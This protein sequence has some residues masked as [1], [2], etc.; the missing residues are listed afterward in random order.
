MKEI[1]IL[2]SS[3]TVYQVQVSNHLDD[4]KQSTAS[5]RCS[6]LDFQQRGTLLDSRF[7]CKHIFF[8]LYKV[9]KFDQS[10]DSKD[11]PISQIELGFDLIEQTNIKVA[12]S[13]N[14]KRAYH[15]MMNEQ[16]VKFNK[17][18]TNSKLNVDMDI[19]EEDYFEDCA[20]CMEEVHVNKPTEPVCQCVIQC[21]KW[22]HTKCIQMMQQ[23]NKERLGTKTKDHR[24]PLCRGS[25][26]DHSSSISP[27]PVLQLRCSVCVEYQPA[28]AH[29]H[30]LS[31]CDLCRS[32]FH[33]QGNI[34]A[35]RHRNATCDK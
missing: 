18:A 34:N 2:G 20:I 19:K 30:V 10:I 7:H 16:K 24:C 5:F 14:L 27:L 26:E 13:D 25:F 31:D 4:F 28:L 11:I 15:V 12:V 33:L 6:C 21:K 35:R 9:F 17:A 1:V 3:G 8:V 32:C 29:T 22:F 23:S